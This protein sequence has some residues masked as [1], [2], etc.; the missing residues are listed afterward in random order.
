MYDD[1]L[2]FAHIAMISF[3]FSFHI[4]LFKMI[5]Y[6]LIQNIWI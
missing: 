3:F 2:A 5:Q 1:I 4:Y 6:R